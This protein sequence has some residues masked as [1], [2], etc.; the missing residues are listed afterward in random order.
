VGKFPAFQS[1]GL[2]A[3]LIAWTMGIGQAK[4]LPWQ[5]VPLGY[6]LADLPN[7]GMMT[8]HHNG[9]PRDPVNLV[10]VGGKDE[11]LKAMAQAGWVAAKP[12]TF[13]RVI[14]EAA[15]ILEHRSDPA[16]PISH[17]YLFNRREDMAFEFQVGGSPKRRHHIRLWEAPFLL[18]GVPVWMGAA[19]F[20]RGVKIF[21]FDHKVE[22]N[23]DEERDYLLETLREARAVSTACYI[24]GF[25]P[26]QLKKTCGFESDGNVAL[27]DLGPPA[28]S[29]KKSTTR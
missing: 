15:C 19:T 18:R 28:G 9:K 4:G 5:N 7:L 21:K 10:L 12:H 6:D 22:K 11:V 27:A 24:P 25:D 14:Q 3:V 29:E 20:D 2:W 1:L 26:L 23:V 16:A 8:L 13:R 17:S